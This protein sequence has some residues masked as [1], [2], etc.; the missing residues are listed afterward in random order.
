MKTLFASFILLLTLSF[1]GYAED[2]SNFSTLKAINSSSQ[3]CQSLKDNGVTSEQLAQ[4]GCC[5]HHG[6]VCG[7]ANGRAKCCDN[8]LSPTCTC[9]KADEGK[10]EI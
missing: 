8:T 4:R 6:G 3:V 5:S 10:S 7:C 1:N 2:Q 9:H